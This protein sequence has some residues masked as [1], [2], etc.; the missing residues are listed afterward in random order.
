M[1]VLRDVHR[2]VRRDESGWERGMYV[3][4]LSD[5]STLIHSPTVLGG[6][7]EIDAIGPPR[8]LFAPNH[9]HHLGLEPYRAR[10]ADARVIAAAGAIPRLRK[11]VRAPI[12]DAAAATLDPQLSVLAC[13][14][15]K[16]GEAFLSLQSDRGRAWIVGDAFFNV[17]TPVTGLTGAFLRFTNT[18]PHLKIGKTFHWLAVRDRATYKRWFLDTFERERPAWLLCA[19]GLPFAIGDRARIV[20]MVEQAFS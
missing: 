13:E 5:G 7:A 3:L 9:F 14:G 8:W 15:L 2:F 1:Q 20:R 17:V 18:V 10:Y 11:K 19:H 16:S 12:E 6:F 4:R